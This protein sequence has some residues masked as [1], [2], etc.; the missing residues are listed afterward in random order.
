MCFSGARW[1]QPV[2][3]QDAGVPP[4][5]R[6]RLPLLLD[7]SGRVLAA[8]DLAF[9]ARFAAWLQAQG[10]RLSWMRNSSRPHD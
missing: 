2:S 6:E 8:G 5:T 4:W 7:P 1:A 3:L 10:M 9:D